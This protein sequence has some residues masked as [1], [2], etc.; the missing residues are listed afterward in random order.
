[1]LPGLLE[2]PE[3]AADP[4]DSADPEQLA[5]PARAWNLMLGVFTGRLPC[6]CC[7]SRLSIVVVDRP[8]RPRTNKRCD[9]SLRL[10]FPRCRM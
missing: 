5:E 2:G 6:P 3:D 7:G 10:G 9:R 4:G 8:R 1:M